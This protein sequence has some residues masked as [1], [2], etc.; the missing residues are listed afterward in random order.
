M[1][2]GGDHCEAMGNTGGRQRWIMRPNQ[3]SRDCQLGPHLCV[4]L[5]RC[6]VGWYQRKALQNG[7]D[8]SGTLGPHLRVHRQMHPVEKFAGGHDGEKELFLL[9]LRQMLIQRKPSAL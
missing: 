7:F 1:D 8:N 9:P 6:Q 3:H 5:G 2:I 4:S